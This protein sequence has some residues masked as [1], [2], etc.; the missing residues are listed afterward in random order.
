MPGMDGIELLR[1]L[2]RERPALS[3]IVMTGH[4]DVSLAVEA[5]KL[6]AF[7]FVEKPF[8]DDRLV[9]MIRMALAGSE[10]AVKSEED[11]AQLS[12]RVASL[13]R[14]E[15]QV[16]DGLVAGLSNK[17]IARDYGISPRTVEVY[18]ANVMS[19]MQASTLSE[20]VRLVVQAGLL[21]N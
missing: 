3:V 1:H 14:R 13:S 7:D 21:K 18:R 16:M 2:R 15:H 17:A 9:D 12:A 6:G 10:H 4:G 5:M 19:K 11:A 20:L 8:E